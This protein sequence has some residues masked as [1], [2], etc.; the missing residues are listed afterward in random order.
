MT[1]YRKLNQKE[2]VCISRNLSNLNTYR[3]LTEYFSVKT[4]Y[5]CE[6]YN[7]LSLYSSLVKVILVVNMK[8]LKQLQ[9]KPKLI[10]NK[11]K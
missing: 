3:T 5:S 1:V 10:A 6:P 11:E 8:Q 4:Y 7:F 2:D 9:G